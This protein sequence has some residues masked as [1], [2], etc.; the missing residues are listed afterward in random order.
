M[1]NIVVRKIALFSVWI[2]S[3]FSGAEMFAQEREEFGYNQHSLRPIKTSD[4]LF[5][6]TLWYLIDLREKQ[7]KPLNAKGYELTG[8][9]IEAVKQG[10]LRPFTDDNLNERLSLDEFMTR[11]TKQK[12]TQEDE[13]FPDMGED[14]DMW[15]NETEQ[16]TTNEPVYYLPGKELYLIELKED[17]IFDKKRSR[18]YR[19]IQTIKLILPAEVN[20]TGVDKEI[21]TFLYK[22]VVENVFKDNPKAIWFNNNNPREHRNMAEAFDLRLFS[23]HLTKYENGEDATIMDIFNGSPE[24]AMYAALQIEYALLEFETNLWEN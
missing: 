5:K 1:K 15:S 21:A 22:E 17:L 6:K 2:A 7:N 12:P 10:L 19:D 3:L 24:A 13:L 4:Q 14:D 23:A 9:L 8:L 11:I 18:M 16:S 20:L